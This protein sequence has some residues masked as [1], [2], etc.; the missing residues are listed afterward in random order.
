MPRIHES[1]QTASVANSA[2]C[3]LGLRF[4][5]GEATKVAESST[6]VQNPAPIVFGKK[7]TWVF[8]AEGNFQKAGLR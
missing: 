6:S 7:I 3:I 5:L 4:T 1:V 2:E 8:S